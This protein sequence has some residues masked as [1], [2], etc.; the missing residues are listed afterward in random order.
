[1]Q[2]YTQK[3]MLFICKKCGFTVFEIWENDMNKLND[4][5]LSIY[6]INLLKNIKMIHNKYPRTIIYHI[7]QVLLMM[8][9]NYQV[10][11]LNII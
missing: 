2:N 4:E 10:I 3:H 9:K 8:I 6:I 11:G 1:M 5:E 7:H